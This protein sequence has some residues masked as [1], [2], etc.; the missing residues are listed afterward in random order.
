[1]HLHSASADSKRV[2]GG[3]GG[4]RVDGG[5]GNGGKSGNKMAAAAAAATAETVVAGMAVTVSRVAKEI[6]VA[7]RRKAE[8]LRLSQTVGRFAPPAT[9]V[10]SSRVQGH[11][12]VASYVATC[13]F[14][15]SSW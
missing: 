3:G 4:I 9:R 12:R 1:M 14:A 10:A 6:L 2:A 5:G 8:A 13:F 7:V 15:T 11:A